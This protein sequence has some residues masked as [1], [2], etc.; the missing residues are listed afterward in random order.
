MSTLSE[1]FTEARKSQSEAQLALFRSFSSKAVESAEKIIALHVTTSRASM[2][3]SA[4][5]MQ[6]LL[7]AKDA[8]ALFAL[9]APTQENIQHFLDYSRALFEIASGARAAPVPAAPVA[10]AA[11]PAAPALSLAPVQAEAPAPTAVAEPVAEPVAVLAAPLA[12]EPAVEAAPEPV[13]VAKAKPLAKAVSKTVAPEPADQPAAAPIPLVKPRALTVSG[14]KPVLAAPP[15]AP[16]SGK[17]ALQA[18]QAEP[19]GARNAKKK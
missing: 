9:A 8:R 7:V 1:Q 2:E 12:A 15:P 3:K 6:K 17:P 10:E 18:K 4:A 5:A 16:A 19:G 11:V 13:P 14:V